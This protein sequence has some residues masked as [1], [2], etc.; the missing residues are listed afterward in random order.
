M[1]GFVELYI[2]QGTTF[3]STINLTDDTTNAPINVAAYTITSQLRRSYISANASG[4]ITCTIT[5]AANGGITL[6]MTSAN[7][8]NLKVGRHVFDV[9]SANEQGV[10]SRLLEGMITVTPGITR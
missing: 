8:A 6:S 2:D 1:A 7:T 9:R 3:N 10:V 4:N 5:D